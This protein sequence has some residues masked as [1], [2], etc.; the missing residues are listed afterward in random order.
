MN[1]FKSIQAALLAFAVPFQ[2]SAQEGPPALIIANW[3][4]QHPQSLPPLFSPEADARVMI[5]AL[6]DQPAPFQ[7]EALATLKSTAAEERMLP[8]RSLLGIVSSE[9]G[10]SQVKMIFLDCC[11]TPLPDAQTASKSVL[12]PAKGGLAP[13]DQVI[14]RPGL[15]IGFASV[16]NQEAQQND[17][18]LLKF[19]VPTPTHGT[20]S[21]FLSK[22][23]RNGKKP[24][25][26]FENVPASL[27][28]GHLSAAMRVGGNLEKVFK[29]AG[30]SVMRTSSQLKEAG[31]FSSIQTPAQYGVFYGSYQFGKAARV[32]SL[33]A[34]E[35]QRKIDDTIKQTEK[36]S[37]TTAIK[38]TKDTP[39]S[40]SLEMKFVPVKIT[41][42]P[43]DGQKV[44]F[45]IWETR[46]MDY[47]AYAKAN[48]GV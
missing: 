34:A 15:F 11:R 26:L 21:E 22:N 23:Y 13:M 4:Y 45:S 38:A 44:L 9:A 30:L 27:F 47:E 14:E 10:D 8:A 28:T 37:A 1:L 2:A 6:K 29:S 18:S 40:N 42:G 48:S 41:G 39:F 12:A 33:T 5:A 19:Q 43:T 3:A 7:I 36:N 25:D 24:S 35:I 20:F 46:R 32:K 17:S 16:A 31:K